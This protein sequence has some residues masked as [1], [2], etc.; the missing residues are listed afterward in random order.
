MLTS[1]RSSTIGSESTTC[2]SILTIPRGRARR[3]RLLG[4]AGRGVASPQ[5]GASRLGKRRT[6]LLAVRVSLDEFADP[7]E[8]DL[9]PGTETVNGR[10]ADRLP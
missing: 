9:L 10:L 3:V 7:V 2:A 6:V 1:V 8:F 5:G 4:S